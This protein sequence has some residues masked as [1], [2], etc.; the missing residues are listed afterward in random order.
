MNF[1]SPTG[2]DSPGFLARLSGGSFGT[3]QTQLAYG[4]VSGGFDFWGAGT[5]VRSDG[6]R[7]H[8]KQTYGRFTGNAGYRFDAAT[9]T[10]SVRYAM[11]FRKAAQRYCALGPPARI[12]ERIREFH[13]AGVRHLVLDLVGPYEQRDVQ[14]ERVAAEVLPLLKD[15]TAPA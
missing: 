8:T 6:Y 2:R 10:L 15:L 3:V 1:V 13:A 11:D 14:L 7:D 12:A 5:L 4:G 9:E